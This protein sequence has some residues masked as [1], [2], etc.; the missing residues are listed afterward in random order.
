MPIALFTFIGVITALLA[1]DITNI[2][3]G[4]LC[5][6]CLVAAVRTQLLLV[7]LAGAL[8]VLH[9]GMAQA[10]FQTTLLP[11]ALWQQ[12][13]ALEMDIDAVLYNNVRVQTVEASVVSTHPN[14]FPARIKLSRY[15]FKERFIPGQRCKVWVK[16]KPI[17]G[18][19]NPGGR[20]FKATWYARGITAQGYVIQKKPISCVEQH[21]WRA[22]LHHYRAHAAQFIDQNIT[23]PSLQSLLKGLALGEKNLS[24]DVQLILQKTGTAHLL[25]ISGLHVGLVAMVVYWVTCPVG[26]LL[27]MMR[28]CASSRAVGLVLSL[29]AVFFYILITGCAVSSQRAGWMYLIGV[30]IF[31]Q[32]KAPP[33]MLLLLWVMCLMILLN[34]HVV[35]DMGFWLSSSMVFILIMLCGYCLKPQKGIVGAIRLQWQLSWAA[36]PLTLLLLKQSSLISPIANII[37]IPVVSFGVVP[38]LLLFDCVVMFSPSLAEFCLWA[39][40]VVMQLLWWFLSLWKDLPVLWEQSTVGPWMAL[41][42]LLASGLWLVPRG[43]WIRGLALYFLCV[44]LLYVA[45][46]PGIG[47]VWVTWLDVGQGLC[48]V[49]QTHAHVMVYDT[50]PK[51]DDFDVASLTLLPYLQYAGIRRIDQLMISHADND[52]RGGIPQLLARMDVEVIKVGQYLPDI[53]RE[54]QSCHEDAQWEWDGVRFEQWRIPGEWDTPNNQSCVVKVTAG[55]YAVLLLGDLEKDAERVLL[56]KGVDLHASVI[57]V[58]HH[59][60]KTSS[61]Q[62]LL[63]AVAPAY[64]IF[65]TGFLNSYHHPH[66]SVVK[67]YDA[68]N[69]T[70]LDTGQNGSIRVTLSGKDD[71]GINCHRDNKC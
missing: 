2:V 15:D 51:Y 49:I 37:A 28:L 54:Q 48:M 59:G 56:A 4:A 36:F 14:P 21:R 34:A 52:H 19:S 3:S 5:V 69:V 38:L 1:L 45:K 20:D 58:P 11:R 24:D 10:T 29:I 53:P 62:A 9:A 63:E 32:Q 70:K 31:I 6:L 64:A 27:V 23:D 57:S 66:P 12:P 55:N 22:L 46:K 39:A 50:G 40:S 71:I 30:L 7:L 41:C 67:R 61:T 65:S 42:L 18:Y 16:L 35:L 60:S 13:T 33:K 8:A 68:L 26:K 17:H 47:E 43:L 25:A 44:P